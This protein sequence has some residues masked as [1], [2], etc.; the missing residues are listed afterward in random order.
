MTLE[1][2]IDHA[3]RKEVFAYTVSTSDDEDSSLSS[4]LGRR[5]LQ[6][7]ARGDRRRR[8]CSGFDSPAEHQ[9]R[10]PAALDPRALSDYLQ[11]GRIQAGWAIPDH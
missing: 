3:Q 11:A 4:S 6:L 1:Q 5:S 2:A 8:L 7:L 10:R 9:L